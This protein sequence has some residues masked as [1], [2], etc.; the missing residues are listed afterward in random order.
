MWPARGCEKRGSLCTMPALSSSLTAAGNQLTRGEGISA[1]VR[2]WAGRELP[3]A[4]P[5][6]S[7]TRQ[8]LA[9]GSLRASIRLLPLLLHS[10]SRSALSLA[11]AALAF[12]LD[13]LRTQESTRPPTS[14]FSF[15]HS[16]TPQSPAD[17][18][19]ASKAE[20]RPE[21]EYEYVS[22]PSKPERA[23]RAEGGGE[24][25]VSWTAE[26]LARRNLDDG[27]LLS[28]STS[29]PMHSSDGRRAEQVKRRAKE[30]ALTPPLRLGSVIIVGAGPAGCMANLCLTTYGFKVLHI[31]NRPTT[32]EAGRADGLQPRT[33][34]VRSDPPSRLLWRWTDSVE[35]VCRSSATLVAFTTRRARRRSPSA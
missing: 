16:S 20:I 29:L 32:T 2:A 25:Q 27:F 5:T 18:A 9:L 6:R 34:E 8:A 10:H 24:A 35:R 13:Q 4:A 31:D 21:S 33:L 14:A 23:G 3:A 26:G 7:P 15:L 19:A 1:R 12:S 28:S 30:R 11:P 22:F 17:M